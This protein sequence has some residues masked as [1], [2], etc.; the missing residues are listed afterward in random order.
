MVEQKLRATLITGR[1]IDQGVGKEMGKGSKEYFDSSAVCFIDKSDMIKL[2]IK[3]GTN[4]QVT[5][6]Y[7]SVI[8]K[9]VKF[10]SGITPGMVFIPAGLWANAICGDETFGMGMPMFKGFS[11]EVQPAPNEVVLSL[12][13]L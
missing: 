10:P 3:S 1:T 6:K 2:N 8:V 4:V 11:V 12:D 9:A 7:G 13:E 5:S